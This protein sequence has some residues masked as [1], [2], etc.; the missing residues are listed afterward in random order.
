MTRAHLLTGT[1]ACAIGL[2]LVAAP[3]QAHTK[4][5]DIAA[6]SASASAADHRVLAAHYRTHAAEHE[7]DAAAH[8]ALVAE[9]KAR[10]GDDDAWDLARD[11]AHYAEHSREAAEALR[12]LARLH[13][14]I[15]ERLDPGGAAKASGCCAKDAQDTATP[16]PAAAPH[17]H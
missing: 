4:R 2:L 15:A 6:L 14:G 8:E 13:E 11:A 12:D 3:V 10:T 1:L 5:I 7:A 17:D 9:A 16:P